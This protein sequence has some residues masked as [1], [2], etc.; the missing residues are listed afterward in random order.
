MKEIEL[1]SKEIKV[2][3]DKLEEIES[4]LKDIKVCP[5]CNR[6]MEN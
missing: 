1:L 2:D 5:Y 6:P 3:S 4:T